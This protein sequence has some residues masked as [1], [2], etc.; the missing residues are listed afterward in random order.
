MGKIRKTTIQPIQDFLKSLANVEVKLN[1]LGFKMKIGTYDKWIYW[2]KGKK[3]KIPKIK[4][5]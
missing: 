4:H 2:T 5:G 1:E 3:I